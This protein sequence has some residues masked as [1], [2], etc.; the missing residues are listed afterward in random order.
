LHVTHPTHWFFII[1]QRAWT[2]LLLVAILLL[3]CSPVP[4]VPLP[5]LHSVP[6]PTQPASTPIALPTL[7]PTSTLFL[8]TPAPSA[9]PISALRLLDDPQLAKPTDF[10]SAFANLRTGQHA[11]SYTL[12]SGTQINFWM[13]LPAAY[14]PT[15]KWPLILYLH[16]SLEQGSNLNLVRERALPKKLEQAPSLPFIVIS[17][18]IEANY[19]Y[20]YVDTLETLLS[21]LEKELPIDTHQEYLTGFS[22]GGY[23][24][25]AYAYH[26][27]ERFAAIAPV[28]GSL[29]ENSFFM[30]P[31]D[32]CRMKAVPVWAFH[33]ELDVNVSAQED[34]ALIKALSEC[35]G[36]AKITLYP[37]V[38]HLLAA[39]LAYADENLYTW[40]LAHTRP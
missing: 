17:P 38:R 23:G 19:W 5:H 25:W 24:T 18:Q 3:A 7:I 32:F 29:D 30:V 6:L 27:P 20:F 33:G 10:S 22:L 8:P 34:N 11:Y 15:K 35:G 2:E 4:D 39:E 14:Q 26:Y 21:G 37:E 13:Y 1:R 16:S 36:E 9:T 12:A 40:L 28:A 31:G